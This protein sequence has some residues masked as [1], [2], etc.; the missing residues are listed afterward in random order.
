MHFTD[1]P[2]S[3]PEKLRKKVYEET[4]QQIEN[5]TPQPTGITKL[6]SSAVVNQIN[7]VAVYQANLEQQR[8][9]AE[10]MRQQ[11]AR[12]LAASTRNLDKALQPLAR[13]MAIWLLV[14]LF[15][16]ISWLATIIDIVRSEFVDPSNKTVWMLLVS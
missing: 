8:R 7:Q 1:S 6:N 5:T 3:V 16:F 4:R 10:S 11:Q 15:I 9:V 12:A 14:G 13:F 2:A